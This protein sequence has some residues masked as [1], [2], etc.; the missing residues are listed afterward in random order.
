MSISIYQ[1]TKK[2]NEYKRVRTLY[3]QGLTTR[4]IAKLFGK[5]RQW[6]WF[7]IKGKGIKEV[8]KLKLS[9]LTLKAKI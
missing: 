1:Q 8:E 3:Q 6:V 7:C 4:D 5:S 9:D 2:L